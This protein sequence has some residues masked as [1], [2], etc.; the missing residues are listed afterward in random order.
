MKKSIIT[1]CLGMLISG[2]SFAQPVSDRAVVPLAVTLNQVLRIH[3]INGGNMEFVFNTIADYKNGKNA[4]AGASAFYQTQVVV[5]S[6]TNWA[7]LFGAEDATLIGTDNAAN[8]M[9]L[10]NVGFSVNWT[11][12]GLNGCCAAG[13][14]VTGGTACATCAASGA[15][16]VPAA[17][18]QW[19]GVRTLLTKGALT[20]GG[21]VT[22]NAFTINWE[23]GTSAA[24]VPAMNATDILQSVPEI[25]PDRYVTNI[26][27]DLQSL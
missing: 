5:A 20:N 8:T 17:L 9:A 3:I 22:D 24:G 6:S 10:N 21:D 23:V 19:N 13:N 1:A 25:Q 15:F 7:I 12:V 14:N 26:L 18:Q 16:G 11:A 4:V 27:F 2:A